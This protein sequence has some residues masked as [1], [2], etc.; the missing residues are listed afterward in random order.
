LLIR[1]FLDEVR[2]NPTGNQITLIKRREAPREARSC[3]S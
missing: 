1:T 3:K 2:F